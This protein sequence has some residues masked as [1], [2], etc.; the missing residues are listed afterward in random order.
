[1][2]RSPLALYLLALV[3]EAFPLLGPWKV[4]DD[5]EDLFRVTLSCPSME[6]SVRAA[7]KMSGVAIYTVF[8]PKTERSWS[9]LARKEIWLSLLGVTSMGTHQRQWHQRRN[10]ASSTPES[11]EERES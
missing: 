5:P 10:R 4:E 1:M 2:E 9:D 8:P 11:P 6:F 3:N 7:Q